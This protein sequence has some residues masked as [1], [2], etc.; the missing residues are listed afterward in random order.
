M[1][2]LS[3]VTTQHALTTQQIT[4]A[5]SGTEAEVK[6]YFTGIHF[7]TGK[8]EGQQVTAW[9]MYE[10]TLRVDPEGQGQ[11]VEGASGNGRWRVCRRKVG[12]TKRLGEEGVMQEEGE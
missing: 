2:R 12:F 9:G 11:G 8:W 6:T 10:D 3:P 5:A 4:I 1:R 7:G